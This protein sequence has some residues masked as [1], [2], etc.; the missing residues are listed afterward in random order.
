MYKV[1]GLMTNKKEHSG[2]FLLLLTNINNNV[3]Y[4]GEK[5]KTKKKK[6]VLYSRAKRFSD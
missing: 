5:N 4:T 1:N 2:I 3:S 6:N